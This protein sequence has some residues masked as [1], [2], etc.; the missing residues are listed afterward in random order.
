MLFSYQNKNITPEM[1]KQHIQCLTPVTYSMVFLH[2]S[3]VHLV[4]MKQNTQKPFKFES[5][6]TWNS[7]I[8]R[9]ERPLSWQVIKV[10]SVSALEADDVQESPW[11]ELTPVGLMQRWA[12][13]YILFL[14]RE[15]PLLLNRCS[16]SGCPCWKSCRFPLTCRV[17]G[18]SSPTAVKIC[19]NCTKML[20]KY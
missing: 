6:Q 1:N 9:S 7:A 14:R 12:W 13:N 19:K 2:Q 4:A 20:C 3:L 8:Y 15:L 11:W 5:H 16:R 18:V 17:R 10:S